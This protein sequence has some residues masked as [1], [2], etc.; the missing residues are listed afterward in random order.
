MLYI[1]HITRSVAIRDAQEALT[2]GPWY[3]VGPP[4][5]V[6]QIAWWV[7]LHYEC[8]MLLFAIGFFFKLSNQAFISN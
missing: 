6:L 8:F 1:A 2:P 7:I 4:K 3:P 5:A